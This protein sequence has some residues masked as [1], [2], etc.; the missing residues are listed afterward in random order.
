MNFFRVVFIP[1]VILSTTAFAL[2]PKI[3]VLEQFDNLNIVTFIGESD[4]N[5]SPVWR[6]DMGT[7]PLSLDAA[8]KAVNR[9]GHSN[10]DAD[11]R[12]IEIRPIPGHIEH[13]HY[14]IKVAND[15]MKTKYNVYVVLMDGKVIPAMI[16]PEGYK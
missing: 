5:N 9:F 7:P 16:E 10:G 15:K 13:W 4:L 6:P 1:F 2:P 8:I 3:E 12:E 11:I 14:L